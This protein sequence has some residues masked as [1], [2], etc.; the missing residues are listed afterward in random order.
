MTTYTAERFT[1]L[2]NTGQVAD[3]ANP[4]NTN[5][6]IYHLWPDHKSIFFYDRERLNFYQDQENDDLRGERKL[7][8]IIGLMETKWA[9]MDRYW[10]Q[11]N[12]HLDQKMRKKK[13]APGVGQPA[14]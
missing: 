7:D 6:L 1:G 10:F 8:S 14:Q 2:I 4:S 3:E 9:R 5:E 13:D 12:R 11:K